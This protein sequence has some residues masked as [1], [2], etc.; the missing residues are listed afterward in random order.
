MLREVIVFIADK[1]FWLLYRLNHKKNS[2]FTDK[3]KK[4]INSDTIFYRALK[5]IL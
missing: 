2:Y 5:G 1:L 3:K 4:T